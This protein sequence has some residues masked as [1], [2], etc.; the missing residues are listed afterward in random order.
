MRLFFGGIGYDDATDHLFRLTA[1][2][3]VNHLCNML[4]RVGPLHRQA[5]ADDNKKRDETCS[6][7]QLQR[8]GL[9][10]TGGLFRGDATLNPMA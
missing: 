4:R 1:N 8:K 7:Q 9:I 5:D 3:L 6:D 2:K 10:D